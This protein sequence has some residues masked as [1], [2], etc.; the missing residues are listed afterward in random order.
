MMQKDLPGS[1][2]ETTVG[3][4]RRLD[5]RQGPALTLTGNGLLSKTL[6]LCTVNLLF[7]K[8]QNRYASALQG[9]CEDLIM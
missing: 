1:V 7:V 9:G 8:W 2:M 3:G 4:W 5:C 6:I